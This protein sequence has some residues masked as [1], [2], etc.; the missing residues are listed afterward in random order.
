MQIKCILFGDKAVERVGGECHIQE[1]LAQFHRHCLL[2]VGLIA[3]NDHVSLVRALEDD[4]GH[5]LSL[6]ARGVALHPAAW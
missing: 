3:C 4:D 1:F 5:A 6:F 2:F